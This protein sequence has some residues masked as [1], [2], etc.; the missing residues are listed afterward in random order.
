ML[1][2]YV[3]VI[4]FLGILLN[5]AYSSP[6]SNDVNLYVDANKGDDNNDGLSESTPLKTIQAAANKATPGTTIHI[7]DGI[8]RETVNTKT[9]EK[10]A[11]IKY[12]GTGSNVIMSGSVPA[13]KFSWKKEK[14]DIWVADVSSDFYAP[15]TFVTYRNSDGKFVRCHQ[16]RTPNYKVETPWNYT[17]F[18]GIGKGGKDFVDCYGKADCDDT[19]TKPKKK[20][21]TNKKETTK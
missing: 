21:S 1:K 17:E 12:V 16:A 11:F 18:W 2:S 3:L 13:S 6:S 8:Y 4:L 5:C 19:D 9:G 10:D 14:N 15:P 7:A 20:R